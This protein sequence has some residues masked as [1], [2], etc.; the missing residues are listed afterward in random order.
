MRSWEVVRRSGHIHKLACILPHYIPKVISFMDN[1]GRSGCLVHGTYY[2]PRD[3]SLT[4]FP[5]PPHKASNSGQVHLHNGGEGPDVSSQPR[6]CLAVM[7]YVDSYKSLLTATSG[8]PK[9]ILCW[10]VVNSSTVVIVRTSSCNSP[11]ARQI[12]ASSA[13]SALH[14]EHVHSIMYLNQGQHDC[15]AAFPADLIRP[16]P[17]GFREEDSGA[18]AILFADR[19]LIQCFVFSCVW[20][21]VNYWLQRL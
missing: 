2:M 12:L 18:G 5:Q 7:T 3:I 16:Q 20:V 21:M 9:E 11:T 10:L 13:D 1:R 15:D 17:I 4:F 8:N 14:K 19:G 6:D